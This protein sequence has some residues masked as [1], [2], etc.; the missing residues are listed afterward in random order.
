MDPTFTTQ[1]AMAVQAEIL[2][3]AERAQLGKSDDEQREPRLLLPA[4]LASIRYVLRR[5]WSVACLLLLPFKRTSRGTN[6]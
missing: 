3:C 2:R 1:Y 5:L 6:S 4:C